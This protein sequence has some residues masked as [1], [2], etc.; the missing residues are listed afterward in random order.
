VGFH[1]IIVVAIAVL[2][3]ANIFTA[4]VAI[5]A[6]STGIGVKEFGTTVLFGN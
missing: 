5:I 6:T 4:V 2:V 1:I 3:V